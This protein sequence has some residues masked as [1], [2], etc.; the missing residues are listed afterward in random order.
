MPH[1]DRF[2][3]DEARA[4]LKRAAERQH[5]ADLGAE[6]RA[7]G[8]SLAD[9]EQAAAA[10]GIEP[11]HVAAAIRDGERAEPKPADTFT[12]RMIGQPTTIRQQRVIPGRLDEALWQKLVLELRRA[13]GNAGT[14]STLGTL[15]EWRSDAQAS[16]NWGEFQAEEVEGEV[17]LTLRRSWT[18]PASGT[19][20]WLVL[21]GF[22]APFFLLLGTQEMPMSGAII[23]ATLS[24][25]ASVL[26]FALTRGWYRKFLD[27]EAVR[28][29]RLIERLDGI[30][31]N[32]TQARELEA[33]RA[34]LQAQEAGTAAPSETASGARLDLD[35][36]S[37]ADA[38]SAQGSQRERTRTG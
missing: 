30:V 2:T 3:E 21:G 32:H 5:R 38:P 23:G 4:I 1:R 28:S 10:A 24:V 18:T 33:A 31:T 26:A 14:P 35:A 37:E 27:K 11:Q 19:A 12:D 22:L 34:A 13:F 20:A 9:L 8:L 16:K 17:H 25:L 7:S 29:E 6:A 36:L 15:H